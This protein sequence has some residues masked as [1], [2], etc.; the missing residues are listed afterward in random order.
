MFISLKITAPD[1]KSRLNF[2]ICLSSLFSDPLGKL[3]N[4]M[5]SYVQLL[6]IFRFS[7]NGQ[8]D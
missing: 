1:I 2:K 4:V 8:K 7:V 5:E 6:D 3:E